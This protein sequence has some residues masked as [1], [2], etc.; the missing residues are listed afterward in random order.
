MKKTYTLILSLFALL[1]VTAQNDTVDI[2]ISMITAP[3]E[4]ADVSGT[5]QLSYAVKNYGAGT[6]GTANLDTLRGDIWDSATGTA[7]GRIDYPVASLTGGVLAANDSIILTNTFLTTLTGNRTI[8]VATTEPN[9]T[10]RSNDTM[11]LHINIVNPDIGIGSVQA[12]ANGSIITTSTTTFSFTITNN[13]TT[14]FIAFAGAPFVDITENGTS[15]TPGGIFLQQGL[16]I[17]A[18]QTTNP[19]SIDVGVTPGN[20]TYCI[21]TDLAMTGGFGLTDANATNDESCNEAEVWAV[22]LDYVNIDIN[23]ISL[24]GD[25]LQ[26]NYDNK[27]NSKLDLVITNILGQEVYSAPMNGG[28]NMHTADLSGINSSLILV[29]ILSDDKVV[30]TQKF[31]MN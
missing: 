7:L 11:A 24:I 27:N 2:G 9:D 3:A 13:G 10:I 18:G 19:L 30:A 21:T 1:G 28:N 15:I 31:M 14:D 5:L 22:G 4:G 29:N 12:P 17:P 16:I 8:Y 23:N 20:N 25:R 6:I 26:V